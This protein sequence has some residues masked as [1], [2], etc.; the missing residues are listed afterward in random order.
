MSATPQRTSRD[1]RR[2][3]IIEVAREVFFEEGYAAA[4]MS[5]IAARLGGSKGTLYNYFRSKEELFEA[6]VR[7]DCDR[8]A[9]DSFDRLQSDDR[10]IGEVLTHLG[11]RY[12]THLFSDWA[13]RTYRVIVAEA[14]RSPQL[15]RLFYEIGP[16]VGLKRLEIY[17]EG[18]RARGVVKIDDCGGAAGEFLTL[19]RGHMHFVY[20]LNLQGPPNPEQIKDQVR[21]AVRLFLKS[22]GA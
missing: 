21:H 8:F 19:C 12:L 4:S 15:A 3:A 16:A 9:E 13:V 17:L 1:L 6:Q 5:S 7:K 20:T 11:E 10:P 2:D 14:I 18:A 22:Y